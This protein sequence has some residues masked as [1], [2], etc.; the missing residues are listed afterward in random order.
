MAL[1]DFLLLELILA[2]HVV[3]ADHLTL[4]M[5]IYYP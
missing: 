2:D 1:L 3:P 5:Q 4:H